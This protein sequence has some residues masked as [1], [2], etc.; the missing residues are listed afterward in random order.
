MRT[1]AI[2]PKDDPSAPLVTIT[3][4]HVKKFREVIRANYAKHTGEDAKSI[5]RENCLFIK[6]NL[7]VE[8]LDEHGFDYGTELE[9]HEK[10]WFAVFC[11]RMLK[12]LRGQP[13]HAPMF[14]E[15]F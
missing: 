11:S 8:A 15:V 9:P 5:T 12:R 2:Q 3:G 14:I 7:A 6:T 10:F 1:V 4:E 13:K